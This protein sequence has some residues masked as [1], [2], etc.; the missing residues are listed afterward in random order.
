VQEL[1]TVLVRALPDG[2]R[3]RPQ[4]PV[5]L[6][7]ENEPEPDFAIVPEGC[8]RDGETPSRAL[9]A[10]EVSDSSLAFDLGR[11]AALYARFGI[12]EDWVLDVRERTLTVHRSPGAT[13][14]RSVKTL[15]DL[16]AV[17]STAVPGLTVDRRHVFARRR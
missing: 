8:G 9:L 12:P 6:D 10:I 13:K 14:Y 5:A 16:L 3:V 15:K 2:Y 1:N 7:D 11:N 17:S 4:L